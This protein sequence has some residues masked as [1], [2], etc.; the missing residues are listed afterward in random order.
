MKKNEKRARKR[1]RISETAE[2]PIITTKE[3]KAKKR[4]RNLSK[5]KRISSV[6]DSRHSTKQVV[7]RKRKK[8]KI[9]RKK[10]IKKTFFQLGA[11][12]VLTAGV[13]YLI[14][15]FTFTIHR[16]EGYMMNPAAADGD[17]VFVNK[18]Q[19]IRRLTWY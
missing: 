13:V 16:T 18:R 12:L 8:R 9:G 11:S 1:A 2:Y 3:K 15:L 17:V 14:S 7:R 6:E 4:K 5:K 10:K 19:A